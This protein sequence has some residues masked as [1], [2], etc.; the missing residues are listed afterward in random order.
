MKALFI[1]AQQGYQDLEYED[2]KKELEEAG[3][4]TV[5]A[6][7][8]I[9]LCKGKLGGSVQATVSIN[10]VNVED[11]EAIIFIGGPGA[12]QYQQ[13]VQAHLTA[14]EAVTEKKVLA[15][16]CIAPTILAY[17]GVLENKKATVWNEDSQ[18]SQILK[19]Q[20]AIYTGKEVTVDG[21]IV[22]ANGPQAAKDFGQKIVQILNS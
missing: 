9:G 6:S 1:L 21:L 4:E 16:I 19:N 14:Q 22:T 3:I 2:T 12:V 18:Q 15:A 10:E 20:G 8:K 7:K 17:A 5:V 13:D 11:Y